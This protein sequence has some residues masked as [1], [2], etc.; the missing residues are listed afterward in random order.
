[1]QTKER[2]DGSIS[3][4]PTTDITSS[5]KFTTVNFR[6][7]T[8]THSPANLFMLEQEK[9]L[10]NLE[11][12]RLDY[13][14][15][16]QNKK[17]A[18]AS[19]KKAA[20]ADKDAPAS[21]TALPGK[22]ALDGADK[23]K[24]EKGQGDT[25]QAAAAAAGVNKRE[26]PLKQE[27]VTPS[28]GEAKTAAAA[29]AGSALQC[30]CTCIVLPRYYCT[31]PHTGATVFTFS[32]IDSAGST[33]YIMRIAL[34][35]GESKGDSRKPSTSNR[36]AEL[37]SAPLFAMSPP[38]GGGGAAPVASRDMTSP[39]TTAVT[40]PSGSAGVTSS[41]SQTH[42]PSF[43]NSY[44]SFLNKTFGASA[45]KDDVSSPESATSRKRGK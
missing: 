13:T 43:S 21:A 5:G 41:L 24:S 17:D 8:V 44:E 26:E 22:K 28:A 15:A 25:V 19:G 45:S 38:Q 6:E 20:A 18:A 42:T 39:T 37:A 4:P 12:R 31:C 30:T 35:T 7:A 29:A 23:P 1:M 2:R 32:F 16:A 10:K 14:L 36:F 33:E 11:A 9:K 40:S 34:L 3:S 27:V